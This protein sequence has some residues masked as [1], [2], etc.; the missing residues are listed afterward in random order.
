M[1]EL[2]VKI[3]NQWENGLRIRHMCHSIAFSYYNKINRLIGFI[4]ALMSAVVGTTIFS[5]FAESDSKSLI[6]IAG[7]M[8]ILAT[9]SSSASA[10]LKFGEL[11]EKH[12]QA[13]ALFGLLRRRLETLMIM[14]KP[15]N[16]ELLTE[17]NNTW[18]EL[19]KSTPA[20]P[21]RIYNLAFEKVK[22]K[23]HDKASLQ[24]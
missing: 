1:E 23:N 12:N 15:I 9:I 16:E 17:L 7:I 10:F 11:A 14:N 4:S 21:Q 2:N 19:E 24:S 20:I 8:S 3:I 13:V 6:I 5:S 22:M 18:S